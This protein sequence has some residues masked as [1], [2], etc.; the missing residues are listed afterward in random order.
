[1]KIG[2]IS[3]SV[4]FESRGGGGMGEGENPP[5]ILHFRLFIS[6]QIASISTQLQVWLKQF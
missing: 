3:Q 2:H 5:F 4:D 1:M 6:L